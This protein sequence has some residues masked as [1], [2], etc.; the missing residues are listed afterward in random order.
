MT[1]PTLI[2]ARGLRCPWPVLRLARALRDGASVELLS[3]DPAAA[4]EVAAFAAGRGLKIIASES[5]AG[6]MR[7]VVGG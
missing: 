7:F 1:G 5:A 2:D 6:S 3:D 4:G